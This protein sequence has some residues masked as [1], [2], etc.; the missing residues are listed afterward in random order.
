MLFA[1][2]NVSTFLIC[3]FLFSCGSINSRIEFWTVTSGPRKIPWC[4]ETQEQFYISQVFR[5][6]VSLDAKENVVVS[7]HHRNDDA[8]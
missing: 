4:V 7:I 1:A 8:I 3:L 6:I 5:K 2:T